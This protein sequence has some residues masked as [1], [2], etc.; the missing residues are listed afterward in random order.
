MSWPDGGNTPY[1]GEKATGWEGGYRVPTLIRWPGVVQPGT[2]YS[3]FFMHEDFLPTF[4]AA[5]G[6]PNIVDEVAHGYTVGD[7]TFKVHLDGH[8]LMPYFTGQVTNSPDRSFLYWSDDGDLFAIRVLNWKIVFIE[9]DNTGLE[10][11]RNGFTTLR[12]PKIFNLRSDPFERG[13]T[14]FEYDD[15]MAHRAYLIVPAQAVVA[16]WLDSFKEFPI[17]QKPASFSL[18]EV[19][20]K[21]QDAGSGGSSQ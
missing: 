8:N 16:N 5:A 21:L 9:N 6:D 18:S 7:K 1:R 2:I 3:D 19:M 17:R 20:S 10:I 4:V 14:S 12:A 11:W 15:W 13:D